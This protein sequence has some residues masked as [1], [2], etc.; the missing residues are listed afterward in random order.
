MAEPWHTVRLTREVRIFGKHP[1]SPNLYDERSNY[2]IGTVLVLAVPEYLMSAGEH[3]IACRVLTKN[4]QVMQLVSYV[5]LQD[6]G[7]KS[8]HVAARE[9]IKK[10]TGVKF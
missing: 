10:N 9:R 7:D 3:R 2:K 6:F 4:T 8:L 5:L 1:N